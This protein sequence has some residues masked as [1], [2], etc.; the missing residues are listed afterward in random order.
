M[1]LTIEV[2]AT[3]TATATIILAQQ[4]VD[5]IRGSEGRSRVPLAITYKGIVYRSS[6]SVYRGQWMMVVNKEMRE[7]GLRPGGKY[8]VDISVD[9]A[10]RTIAVPADF[11]KAMKA[12][13]VRKTF[14][15]LSY[16]RRK[17]FVRGIEDAKRPETRT[18][19]I[20]TAVSDLE[21]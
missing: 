15:A 12:A 14:D 7:G 13:G 4:Q 17:E 18:R 5:A 21:G 10:E 2:L 16:S 8:S 20:E 3:G 1:K 6:I 9:T 11:A 19:R